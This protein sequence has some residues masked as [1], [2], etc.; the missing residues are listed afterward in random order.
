MNDIPIAQMK[1]QIKTLF[2]TV[3]KQDGIVANLNELTVEIK[4]LAL[5]VKNLKENVLELKVNLNE[6]KEKPLKRY[7][8]IVSQVLIFIIGVILSCV[9]MK[10]N[11]K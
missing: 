6:L 1:E 9:V 3:K 5:E 7:E 11:L 4:G 2:E 10:I 8:L